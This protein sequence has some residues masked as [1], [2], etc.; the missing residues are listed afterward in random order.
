V[1]NAST[2]L[3]CRCLAGFVCTYT[4]R[5]SVVLTLHEITWNMTTIAGLS[6]SAVIDAIAQAAGVAR[7]MVVINGMFTGRRRL[8]GLDRRHKMFI[9]VSGAETLDVGRAY[10]LLGVKAHIAWE[11]KHALRVAREFTE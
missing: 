9:T 6:Q 2:I 5:I 10:E 1:G 3:D 7:G 8:M 11:H 4:K